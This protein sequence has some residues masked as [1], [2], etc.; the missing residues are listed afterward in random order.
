MLVSNVVAALRP[1]VRSRHCSIHSNDL[2]VL[3]AQTGLYTYPDVV[4][5]CG[6]KRVLDTP[7]DT[8]VSPTL[9][10]GAFALYGSL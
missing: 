3:V 4:V 1:Q 2:R 6:E 10:G 5:V 9:M 7:K 8:L